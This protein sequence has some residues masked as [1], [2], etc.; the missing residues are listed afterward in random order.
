MADSPDCY[1]LAFFRH[2]LVDLVQ[3]RAFVHGD[4]LGFI[5]FD[6]ILRVGHRR[7]VRVTLVLEV[8]GVDSGNRAAY[9][10]GLRVPA[11]MV[12]NLEFRGHGNDSCYVHRGCARLACYACPACKDIIR[13]IEA[14]IHFKAWSTSSELRVRPIL[15]KVNFRVASCASRDVL[16]IASLTKIWL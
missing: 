13:L 5:A 9:R 8:L 1:C 16:A 7:M 15:G 10:A 4:V 6:C 3:R 14:R 2:G 11:H 12:A